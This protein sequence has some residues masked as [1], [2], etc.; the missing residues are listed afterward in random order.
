MWTAD[1]DGS[2]RY[3]A[4]FATG[5]GPLPGSV[6]LGSLGYP[7]GTRAVVLRTGQDIGTLASDLPVTLPAH[8]TALAG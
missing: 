4:A 1:G 7:P 2:S 3:L 8:G 5:D 6:A